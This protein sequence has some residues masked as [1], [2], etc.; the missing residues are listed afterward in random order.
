MV[1]PSLVGTLFLA[2]CF[3]LAPEDMC[4][5]RD[6]LVVLIVMCRINFQSHVTGASLKHISFSLGFYPLKGTFT[7]PYW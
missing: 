7:V 4:A 1:L 2:Q 6:V 3:R 5:Y